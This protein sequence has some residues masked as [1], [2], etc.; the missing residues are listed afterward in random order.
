MA[1][2]LISDYSS[3]FFDYAILRRPIRCFAYDLDMYKRQRGF[4]MNIEELPSQIFLDEDSL[5][6]SIMHM[7]WENDCKLVETFANKFLPYE[8]CACKKITDTLLK[9]LNRK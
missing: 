1:D 5:L 6:E 4:Y 9:R 3:A 7:D 2:V 8:G